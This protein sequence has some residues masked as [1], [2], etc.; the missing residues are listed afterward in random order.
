[1]STAQLFY[2]D[3]NIGD[4]IR[5][6]YEYV[7]Q[8]MCVEWGY[9]SN[10]SNVGHWHIWSNRHGYPEDP[11]APVTRSGNDPSLHGQFKTALMEKMLME[12]GGPKAWV[13]KMNIQYRVWDH[14]FELKCLTGKVTA[15]SEENDEYLV[16]VDVQ[17]AREDGRMT[18]KGTATVALP[19]E[20]KK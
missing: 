15:K 16:D 13:V 3:V 19:K 11:K 2:D 20:V 4:D 6:M 18:T 7:D 5:P 1:M 17:M 14:P 8:M 10:N 9:A 12:W